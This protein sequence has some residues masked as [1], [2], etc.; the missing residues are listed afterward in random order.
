M[1]RLRSRLN[2][3]EDPRSLAQF[4]ATGVCG[5]AA[6]LDIRS[7][8]VLR[9]PCAPARAVV[10]FGAVAFAAVV[11]PA[12]DSGSIA[13][14]AGS[15]LVFTSDR[16]GDMDVYAVDARSGRVATLTR[17][18]FDDYGAGVLTVRR[19]S[20]AQTTIRVSK[21]IVDAELEDAGLFYAWNDGR[22]SGKIAFIPMQ[23]L[24]KRVG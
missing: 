13:A 24:L 12:G 6:P 11:S 9:W 16:D 15:H 1:G 20:G 19:S 23:R 3:P 8:H 5:S 7:A 14:S 17:N 18:W 10:A 2:P 22:G 21:R 4:K